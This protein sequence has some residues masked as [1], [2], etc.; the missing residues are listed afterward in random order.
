VAV[1]KGQ[2]TSIKDRVFRCW[3]VCLP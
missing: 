3:F 1:V 2:A